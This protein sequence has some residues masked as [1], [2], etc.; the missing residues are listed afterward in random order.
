MTIQEIPP[1][2]VHAHELYGDYWF[3]SDPVPVTAMKG[4]VVLLHFWDY[5][6]VASIRSLPYIREWQRKYESLGLV[7]VAVHAPK[8]DFAKDPARVGRAIEQN[9]IVYPVVMDNQHLITASYNIQAF[10]SVVLVDRHGFVRCRNEGDRDYERT[11][12][13]LRSLI[14][15]AG[16]D[17]D[18]PLPMQPIREEDR[19]G[20]VCYRVTPDLSA[21][22]TSRNIGNSEG[23]S[24]ESV[25][26]YK[27][28]G[29]YVEGKLYADGRWFNGRTFIRLAEG[30]KP[31]R[32]FVRY[33]A[34]EVHAVLAS[35]GNSSVEVEILR[36][37]ESLTDNEKAEDVFLRTDG[38]SVVSVDEPRSYSLIRNPDGDDHVACLTAKSDSFSFYSFSFIS[39][40]VPESISRN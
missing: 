27:D 12:H 17:R 39:A 5:A 18:L 11:E 36:D 29:L 1:Q 8:Y 23:S 3:N 6:S 40:V 34:A 26:E 38:R 28:P 22:Y 25:V 2:T 7:T 35:E 31:G 16:V 20:A 4:R 9:G 32:I 19:K 24:P 21:G 37:G 10:P 15:E 33:N 30:G 13:A 14:L